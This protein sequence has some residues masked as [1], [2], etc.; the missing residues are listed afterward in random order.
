MYYGLIVVRDTPADGISFD[1]G[2]NA[3]IHGM[4][5]VEGQAKLHGDDKLLFDP[6][7]SDLLRNQTVVLKAR[8]VPNTW[9]QVKPD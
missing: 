4:V 7:I 5:F 6:A 2:G 1:L 8:M 9:R 3:S